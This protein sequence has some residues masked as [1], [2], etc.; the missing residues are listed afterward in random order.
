MPHCFLALGGNTGSVAETFD[1]VLDGLSCASTTTVDRVSQIYRTAAV[2]D[3]AGGEF[4]NAAAGIETD[5][6]PLELL[7]LLQSLEAASGRSRTTHW[8]PR[9][10]D[11]D[12][13]L[14]GEEIL[15]L[16]RLQVPHPACWYRRFVLDP[17]AEIA[18]EA[19]H[20]EREATIGALRQRLLRRPFR[21]CLTG[22]TSAVRSGLIDVLQPDFVDLKFEH[23]ETVPPASDEEATLLVWLGSENRESPS[24][25]EFERLPKLS[26]LDASRAGNDQATFLRDVLVSA[27]LEPKLL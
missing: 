20:P 25:T 11:L 9:P 21:V 16:P 26:R 15:D 1:R 4:L 17:L 19:V 24:A 2:G 5:L 27:T 3:H 22:S 12:L 13:I 7:D 23:S 14:Y 8:G 10:I 6:A 18:A